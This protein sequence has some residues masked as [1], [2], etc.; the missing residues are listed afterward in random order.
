MQKCGDKRGEATFFTSRIFLFFSWGKKA[1]QAIPLSSPASC[2][3]W[4][5]IHQLLYQFWHTRTSHR[6]L[7]QFFVLTRNMA[8]SQNQTWE[9]FL[10]PRR[11]LHRKKSFGGFLLGRTAA[12]PAA[13]QPTY[14]KKSGRERGR[15]RRR[16]KN[17][18]K[19]AIVALP[20][21]VYNLPFIPP[22][23]IRSTPLL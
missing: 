10:P 23:G 14:R 17:W 6:F 20:R 9:F 11:P 1:S 5:G 7:I 12:Q 16:K 8:V 22:E 18:G 21:L 4:S 19:V 13:S 15:M 2:L 3:D